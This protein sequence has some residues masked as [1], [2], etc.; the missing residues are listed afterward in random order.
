M[1]LLILEFMYALSCRVKFIGLGFIWVTRLGEE[2]RF[3]LII[4]YIARNSF[5]FRP[6][7]G[8]LRGCYTRGFLT[9]IFRATKIARLGDF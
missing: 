6:L 8:S 2:E 4:F 1:D 3:V 9:T 5:T 7:A